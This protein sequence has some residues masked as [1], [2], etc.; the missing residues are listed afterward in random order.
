M[1]I[2]IREQCL[3]AF[4][5]TLSGIP[6]VTAYRNRDKSVPADKTPALVQVDGGLEPDDTTH[7]QMRY[8]QR[9][10]IECFVTSTLDSGLGPATSDLYSKIILAVLADPLLNGLADDVR[11]KSMSDPDIDYGEGK[12]P[13]A[14]FTLSFEIEFSTAVGN[15]QQSAP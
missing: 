1:T 10:T 15:P 13:T 6:G 11:E 5:A 7:G 2:S 8:I 3:A 4:F 14:K 9:I 12:S